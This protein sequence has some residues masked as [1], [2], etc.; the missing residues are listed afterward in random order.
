MTPA[1]S[2]GIRAGVLI[3]VSFWGIM[4]IPIEIVTG[5]FAGMVT[6]VLIFGAKSL[7]QK[8]IEP[9]YASLRY[10]GADVSGGWYAKIN[11]TKENMPNDASEENIGVSAFSLVL[12]Q[13]AHEVSGSLQFDFDGAMKKFNIDYEVSG[14]YWE[15]YLCLYCKSKD[16]RV[17]SQA[18]IFVK[19]ISNG[20]GLLG[21]LSFRDAVNDKVNFIWLGLDR[22]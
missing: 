12:R 9:W 17:F 20:T 18:S 5:V 4:D 13:N 14:E 10:K 21:V 8:N 2:L 7:W 16:K 6:S 15:G 3:S 19:L 11:D 1:R 22:N